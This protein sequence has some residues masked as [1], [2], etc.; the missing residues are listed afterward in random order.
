MSLEIINLLE[1]SKQF[2]KE[3]YQSIFMRF[4]YQNYFAAFSGGL[5]KIESSNVVPDLGNPIRNTGD[6]LDIF[7]GLVF[8]K[9]TSLSIFFLYVSM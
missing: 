5:L 4:F 8:A 6:S 9:K 1:V 3:I 2:E 7:V